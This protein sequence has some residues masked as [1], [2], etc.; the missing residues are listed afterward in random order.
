M[1]MS[2]IKFGCPAGK[3]DNNNMS[4]YKRNVL[5]LQQC[6]FTPIYIYFLTRIRLYPVYVSCS[7]RVGGA[8][9]ISFIYKYP[10]YRTA[11]KILA[12]E[13]SLFDCILPMHPPEVERIKKFFNR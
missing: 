7:H 13:S 9:V 3:K 6:L 12:T 1:I 4:L 8:K 5:A 10:K 2:R 11:I